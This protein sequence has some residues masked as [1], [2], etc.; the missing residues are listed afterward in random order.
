MRDRRSFGTYEELK[1][2]TFPCGY[3]D[4]LPTP[5]YV[6]GEEDVGSAK[7]GRGHRLAWGRVSYFVAHGIA[8]DFCSLMHF[9]E[10]KTTHGK[11]V[12]DQNFIGDCLIQR[13][14]ERLT[15]ENVGS[16][17]DV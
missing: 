12:Q 9:T 15:Q 1:E 7:L 5:A 17:F 13:E 16:P 10:L 14:R 3:A 6:T 8:G 2:S 4:L 11:T